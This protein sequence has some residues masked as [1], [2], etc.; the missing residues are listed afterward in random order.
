[1]T[2]KLTSV[3]VPEGSVLVLTGVDL[4]EMPD[5]LSLFVDEIRRVAGHNRF[6]VI[7]AQDDAELEVWGPDV[8]LRAKVEELLANRTLCP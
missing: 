7:H 4:H 8:D 2:A 3:L 1:M 6:V 5:Q